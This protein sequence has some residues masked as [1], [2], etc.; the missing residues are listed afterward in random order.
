V[1]IAADRVDV[2]EST[3][4]SVLRGKP[5]NLL[6]ETGVL[7]ELTHDGLSSRFGQGRADWRHH[8][9]DPVIVVGPWLLAGWAAAAVVR[10]L[11]R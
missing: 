2:V 11:L 3:I 8:V 6:A 4:G 10:R 7:S 1:L 5:D 9:L